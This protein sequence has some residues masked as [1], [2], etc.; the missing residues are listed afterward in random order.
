MPIK[1][2]IR[3]IEENAREIKAIADEILHLDTL[4][5]PSVPS[6]PETILGYTIDE[7]KKVIEFAHT[8]GYHPETR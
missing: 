7:L 2:E 6:V 8:K 4:S 3:K 5:K 1:D